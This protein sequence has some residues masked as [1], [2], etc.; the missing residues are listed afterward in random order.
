[1]TDNKKEE[2]KEYDIYRDSL[3]RY[4][5]EVLTKIANICTINMMQ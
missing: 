2:K 3:L 5:G 1:M 4:L